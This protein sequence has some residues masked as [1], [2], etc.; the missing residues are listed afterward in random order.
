M[1]EK[2]ED[3]GEAERLKQE[4]GRQTVERKRERS[5]SGK[6]RRKQERKKERAIR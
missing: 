6:V 3:F 2:K 1:G 5:E 4:K